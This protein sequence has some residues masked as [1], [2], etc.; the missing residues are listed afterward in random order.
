MSLPATKWTR[1]A[2]WGVLALALATRLFGLPTFPLAPV[3]AEH[4][5]ASLDAV[6]GEG[7]VGSSD[8]PLLLVGNGLLFLLFGAGDG[9]A[10]LLPAL[11]GV[12][13]VLL[14]WLWRR[15][16][17]EL[18]ALCASTL[19]LISPLTLFAA[20]RV[21][22]A[23][24]AALSGGLIV[25]VMV[26]ALAPSPKVLSSPAAW[27]QLFLGSAVAVGLISGP[28][29]YDVLLAGL[30]ARVL[31][32]RWRSGQEFRLH[33]LRPVLSGVGVALLISIAA[34][35]RWSGWSG[36]LDSLAAWLASWRAV[37]TSGVGP[38]ALLG[39]YE[40][41]LLA[42]TVMAVVLFSVRRE[43]ATP[44]F[45]FLGVWALLMLLLI[46]A[47]PGALPVESSVIVLPLALLAGQAATALFAGIGEGAHRWVGLHAW[48]GFLFWIPG[49]VA[50]TQY[51]AGFVY[52]DQAP[53]LLVGMVVLLALQGLLGF[54]LSLRLLPRDLWRGAV[55]GLGGALFVLQAS[56]LFGLVYLRAD[57][58]AELAVGV[59]ASQD[60][61][62]LEE[63]VH[64]IAI[65]QD[66][67]QDALAIFA[68]D[69]DP[70]LS[71]LIR[72]TLR[73]FSRLELV[74]DWPQVTTQ[75]IDASVRA[76]LVITPESAVV[77]QPAD[78]QG[79][80]GMR[81]V[82]LTSSDAVPPQCEE[83]PLPLCSSAVRWYLYRGLPGIPAA[84]NLILWQQDQVGW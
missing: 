81:F 52:V 63:M 33:W 42:C 4:A 66:T 82:A 45:G 35:F 77:T 27:P 3:E 55:L 50:L 19:L 51:A 80:Q 78:A 49:L 47:R 83:L 75:D 73:D 71:S 17:G 32:R 65:L 11:A 8:S 22:G 31:L 6:R 13:L 39:C 28:A 16:L 70:E 9:I 24:L 69:Q 26:W 64:Q 7:W 2:W 30:L 68:V 67:R 62:R 37:R 15:Q 5:L 25:T 74:A 29:F 76:P 38:L 41:L 58:P 12:G 59:A 61:R 18:G 60:L 72:W 1:W 44:V 20:R 53:L 23:A 34:G 14:P 84:K 46:M 36:P 56:F 57:S 43:D 54:V 10:R 79:W 21:D 48:V 40:P